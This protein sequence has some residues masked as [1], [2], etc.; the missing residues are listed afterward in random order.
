[1]STPRPPGEILLIDKPLGWTS[2]QA[3]KKIKYTLK[4]RRVGHAGTLDPLAT[5]LL[6][7]CTE[8]STRKI[9]E[10]QAAEKEYTGI[11]TL[12]SS[13]PSFDLETEPDEHKPWEFVTPELIEQTLPAFRGEIMQ[14]PPLYSAIKVSGKRAYEIAR[15]GQ[16]HEMKLRPTHIYRFDIEKIAGNELHFR[17]VCSKGTYI[18]SLAHDFAK[19]L[20]TLGH[21][22][23]LVRTR[24]GDY[25]LENA[26]SPLLVQAGN[27]GTENNVL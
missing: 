24:I 23:K 3:V 18:R 12:G 4:A 6:I 7:V 5:G 20:G 9:E 1:M 14:A 8:G 17:V 15:S 10:I 27:P 25:R 11:I 21:L 26:I 13:T 2:F 22:S 19:A 16:S